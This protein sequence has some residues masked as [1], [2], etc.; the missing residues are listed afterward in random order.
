MRSFSSHHRLILAA[1]AGA[2]LAL[3]SPAIGQDAEEGLEIG[4]AP[5]IMPAKENTSALKTWIR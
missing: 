4:D 1:L 5:A 2:C 3:A